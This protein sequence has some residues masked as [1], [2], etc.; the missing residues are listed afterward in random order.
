MPNLTTFLLFANEPGLND[1]GIDPGMTFTLFLSI[2]GSV[3]IQT[4]DFLVVSRAVPFDFLPN[5]K[6]RLE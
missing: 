2:I 3:E 5:D 6:F 1:I 4:H